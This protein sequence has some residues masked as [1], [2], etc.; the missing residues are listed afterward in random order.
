MGG[1]DVT[2]LSRELIVG[3]I[4]DLVDRFKAS[5]SPQVVVTLVEPR[6][7]SSD[8]RFGIDNSEYKHS[9]NF[10]NRK[11]KRLTHSRKFRVLNINARPFQTGHTV[12]GVHFN[13]QSRAAIVEKIV[14]CI[15]HH[16]HLN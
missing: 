3:K 4:L 7:Y 6:E 14:N 9:M 1:N 15:S 16:F 13:V 8:N 11:L 2:H 5:G 12:D 10:I